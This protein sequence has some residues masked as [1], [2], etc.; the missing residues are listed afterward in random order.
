MTIQLT[1]EQIKAIRDGCEGVT[2]GHLKH[3]WRN[4]KRQPTL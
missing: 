1:D 4:W 2:P 3:A